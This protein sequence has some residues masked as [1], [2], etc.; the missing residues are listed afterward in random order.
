[1][2]SKTRQK[3]NNERNKVEKQRGVIGQFLTNQCNKKLGSMALNS[4]VDTMI[5]MIKEKKPISDD[6]LLL[7]WKFEL[8]KKKKSEKYDPLSSPL[9]KAIE[10]TVQDVLT[11][12]I[13]KVDW[14][15]FKEYLFYSS[16][17]HE[18]SISIE[19]R[20]KLAEMKKKQG[21]S[22]N[23]EDE[24]LKV[25]CIC[26]A[27]ME[28]VLPS[29][30]YG[31]GAGCD[32]CACEIDQNNTMYH[33]PTGSNKTHEYG[34]DYCM[35]CARKH[36]EKSKKSK[37]G[38]SS[39]ASAVKGLGATVGQMIKSGSKDTSKSKNDELESKEESINQVI[40]SNESTILYGKL[41]K[42]CD[43]KLGTPKKF[44]KEKIESL[45]KSKT[46]K[47]A[48]MELVNYPQY[49]A[50]DPNVGLRQ[51]GVIDKVSGKEMLSFPNKS[52][53]NEKQLRDLG[54]LNIFDSQVYLTQLMVVAKSLNGKFHTDMKSIFR[55][56]SKTHSSPFYGITDY[57]DGKI[58]SFSRCV[59]KAEIDYRSQKFPTTS[60]ILDIIRCSVSCES[61]EKLVQCLK[62][63]ENT[64]RSA[65]ESENEKNKSLKHL[66]LCLKRILRVKN[67]FAINKRQ[68]EAKGGNSDKDT[69]WMYQYGDVKCNVLI[70]YQGKSMIVGM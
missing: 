48:W 50:C 64:I 67:R 35:D 42:I 34:H 52:T 55:I 24:E 30:V 57:R 21:S 4:I 23:D 28:K 15:W 38:S 1:M 39:T 65:N 6:L 47:D 11:I 69:S 56:K 10:E 36:H 3:V 13:N 66:G 14:F 41:V 43:N 19:M 70:E 16:I 63:L 8:S 61:S 9:W 49:V 26:G 45:M 32:D 17:W 68:F 62:I 58:K 46:E 53:A 37:G 40:N 51:D 18:D 31:G 22:E 12:P 54:L 29:V 20:N 33:C 5:S 27:M 44:L 7:C 59:A 25:P 2:G 60:C